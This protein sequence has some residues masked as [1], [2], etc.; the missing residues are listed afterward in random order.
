MLKDAGVGLRLGSSRSAQG[1][2]VHLDLA[3]PLNR[4]RSIKGV[5]YLVTTS[6]T[7]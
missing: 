1:A 7:F 6:E 3:V 4:G 5:Q 2:I